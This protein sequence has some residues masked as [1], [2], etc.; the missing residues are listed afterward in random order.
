MKGFKKMPSFVRVKS[1]RKSKPILKADYSSFD[2]KKISYKITWL[3]AV[4]DAIRRICDKS[5]KKTFS[6]RTLKEEE[7]KQIIND[8]GSRGA[9][10][11]QTL[12]AIL[13]QL[14]DK[15]IIEFTSP[16]VYR[17]LE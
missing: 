13:Q 4:L 17:L 1:R 15:K 9:T 2:S 16:G 3:E 8:T 5:G 6:R 14:R 10:P 7:L 11:H 12:S